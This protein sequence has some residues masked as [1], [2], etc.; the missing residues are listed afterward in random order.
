MRII[1]GIQVEWMKLQILYTNEQRCAVYKCV[2]RDECIQLCKYDPVFVSVFIPVWVS[3]Y[4]E[5]REDY[6]NNY[7]DI[8]KG[9][10][11]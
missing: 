4:Y 2:H 10:K 5:Y 9:I 11:V 1:L 6:T 8:E 3:N 7:Y